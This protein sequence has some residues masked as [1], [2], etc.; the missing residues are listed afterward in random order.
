MLCG[1]ARCWWARCRIEVDS[2][3]D[4]LQFSASVLK[5]QNLTAK[6]D[7]SEVAKLRSLFGAGILTGFGH[8]N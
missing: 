4:P 6:S 7:V 3:V 5:R 8:D 2:A 1:S